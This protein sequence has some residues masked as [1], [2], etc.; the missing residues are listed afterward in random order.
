MGG[1]YGAEM[2]RF[3]AEKMGGLGTWFSEVFYFIT[4]DPLWGGISLMVVF[5]ILALVVANRR[6]R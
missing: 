4:H 3:V 5:L 2:A 1:G 6:T